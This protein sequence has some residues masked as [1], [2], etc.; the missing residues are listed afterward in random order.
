MSSGGTAAGLAYPALIDGWA[1]AAPASTALAYGDR[2]IGAGELARASGAVAA[3]LAALGLKAGDRLA[4]WLPNVPAWLATFI[5]CARLGVTVV[6]VNT[7]FRRSEIEELFRR[8]RPRA[9]ILWPGFRGIDFPGILGELDRDSLDGIEFMIL[10]SEGEDRAPLPALG[11]KARVLDY[12]ALEG[13]DTLCPGGGRRTDGSVIFTTSG[14]TKAP[15]LVLHRQASLVDH[16]L[17]VAERFDWRRPGTVTLQLLPLC[18]TF[19]LSQANGA[20][21]ARCPIVLEPT[22]DPAR[23]VAAMKHHRATHLFAT[24]DMA[25]K[26]LA[27]SHGADDFE[28]VRFWGYAK[29]NPALETLPQDA[30]R[31]G[32]TLIGAYGSSELQAL[33]ACQ[34]PSAALD[35]RCRPGGFPTAAASAVRVRGANGALAAANETGELECRSPGLFAHYLD[36]VEATH[37][38]MTEDGFFRTGDLGYLRGDGSFVFLSRAGDVLRLSGFLVNPA[39]IESFIEQN[40]S[41][42]GCQVVG[43]DEASGTV[44]VAFVTVEAGHAFDEGALRARCESGLARYK[45]PRR[46]VPLAE[47]P[48]TVS[49]NGT[50]VQR[51]KL[52]EMAAALLQ[53]ARQ[54]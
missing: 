16:A 43:V 38:A 31:R 10:Y 20:L 42:S 12:G 33:F 24:D 7:R 50:K 9:L 23:A 36:D 11:G 21:A 4:I 2:R 37:A 52:R 51:A 17:A 44:P 14:T 47:F 32:V 39:E 8:T 35:D 41:I 25:A 27:E 3:G 22:F 6:S 19:G 46:F 29:F 15:K 26:L 28:S 13:A 30:E 54:R 5:A 53:G 48:V 18:G 34:D 45:V 1:A 40:E 49:A